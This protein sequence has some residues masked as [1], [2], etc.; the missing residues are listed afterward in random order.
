ML[1]LP[2]DSSESC[3]HAELATA[4]L[5]AGSTAVPTLSAEVER[6][7]RRSDLSRVL[8]WKFHIRGLLP[9]PP[10][11]PLIFPKYPRLRTIRAL[12]KGHWGVLVE[13]QVPALSFRS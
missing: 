4:P 6:N 13:T 11:Y 1:P 7:H 8:F 2:E 3:R 12:L 10:N 5:P 9:R